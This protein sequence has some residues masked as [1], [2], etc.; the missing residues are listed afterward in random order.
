MPDERI[1]KF[2]RVSFLVGKLLGHRLAFYLL[3]GSAHR[4]PAEQILFIMGAA[5]QIVPSASEAFDRF[6]GTLYEK[7]ARGHVRRQDSAVALGA[8]RRG[9]LANRVLLRVG[10]GETL[11]DAAAAAFAVKERLRE[12][13]R[14]PSATGVLF[15]PNWGVTEVA[16]EVSS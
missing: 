4:S 1:P 5:S 9:E 13:R 15:A 14:G 10:E 8:K 7:S 16:G 11:G 12:P 6:S 2:H 3:A